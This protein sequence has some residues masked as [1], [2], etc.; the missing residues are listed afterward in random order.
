MSDY[1]NL[2]EA[3][4]NRTEII[5]DIIDNYTIDNMAAKFLDAINKTN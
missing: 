1:S 3:K 4:W 2:C 5:N